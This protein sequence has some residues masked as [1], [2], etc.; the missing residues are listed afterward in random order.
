MSIR[1]RDEIQED[2][3]A[4]CDSAAA[5]LWENIELLRGDVDHDELEGYL[6]N[7]G[8]VLGVLAADIFESV[9]VLLRA[10][11][12]RGANMLSR[13]LVDYDIRLRYYVVQSW[14][15]RR[16]HKTDPSIPLHFLLEQMDAARDWDNAGFKLGSVLNLYDPQVWPPEMREAL[17]RA[18]AANES[19]KGDTFKHMLM[20]L[21]DQESAIRGVIPIWQGWLDARYGN[22]LAG[23]RMQSAFLHGDQVVVSDV[24]EFDDTAKTTGRLFRY[25]SAPVNTILFMAMD[26]VIE[27]ISSFGMFRSWA[28]GAL[29]LC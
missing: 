21:Q 3:F 14:K 22:M 12:I 2:I 25:S 7:W 8:I 29:P 1:P 16:K 18:M 13:A 26:H 10:G 4:L 5:C 20:F 6:Y 19:E 23:W 27:I 9:T 24:L 15:V 11:K 17:E 28:P